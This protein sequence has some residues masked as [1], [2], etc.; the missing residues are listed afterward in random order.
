MYLWY[1]NVG[2]PQGSITGT[3]I[4]IVSGLWKLGK[5]VMKLPF[6][7]SIINHHNFVFKIERLDIKRFIESSEGWNSRKD[8]NRIPWMMFY[9]GLQGNILHLTQGQ[10]SSLRK[11]TKKKDI[12]P[13][14]VKSQPPSLP[15]IVRRSVLFS[16]W[17]LM[18]FPFNDSELQ[19]DYLSAFPL[20]EHH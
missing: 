19:R 3:L 5:Q 14:F 6:F 17:S 12:C 7:C 20:A 11:M 9:P 10:T 18:S 4:F 15:G 2:A 1:L 8:I 13:P 16:S